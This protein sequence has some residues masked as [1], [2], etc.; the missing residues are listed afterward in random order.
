MHVDGY[1]NVDSAGDGAGVEEVVEAFVLELVH[2]LDVVMSFDFVFHGHLGLS[3]ISL[4]RQRKKGFDS[5][6][7]K[8]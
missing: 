8:P 3:G 7:S 4:L 2:L 5:L 1:F 6:Q